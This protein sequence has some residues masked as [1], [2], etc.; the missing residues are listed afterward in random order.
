MTDDRMVIMPMPSLVAL[1]LNRER[2]KGAPLT[3]AEVLAIRDRCECTMVPHEIV[4]KIVEARGYD[5]IRPEHVWE[6]WMVIRPS[7]L[8]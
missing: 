4:A 5:D 8:S 2:A 1:L 7:L 6:D 3:E